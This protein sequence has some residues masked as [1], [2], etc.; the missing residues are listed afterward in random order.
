MRDRR[1]RWRSYPSSFVG[2]VCRS[3]MFFSTRFLSHLL[4][5][6][7]CY[8]ISTY[9]PLTL[10]P[11]P[12]TPFRSEA[13][14][15]MVETFG[16]TRESAASFGI[17]MIDRGEGGGGSGRGRLSEPPRAHSGGPTGLIRHVKRQHTFKD[18]FYFYEFVVKLLL[19]S[20]FISN[21]CLVSRF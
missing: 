12:P 7:L 15:W 4:S 16:L 3:V 20:S 9:S 13:V 10:P 18:A 17:E 19:L 14:D 11:R 2:Y 8:P 6:V 1:W 5:L 21:Q